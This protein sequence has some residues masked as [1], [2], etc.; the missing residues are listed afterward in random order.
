MTDI[1]IGAAEYGA[2]TEARMWVHE[3]EAAPLRPERYA[4]TETPVQVPVR[5]GISLAANLIA[6]TLPDGAQSPPCVVVTNGYSGLDFSLLPTLRELAAAGYPV[7]L[8]RL[9]GVAPSQG[10][11]GLY[12]M[13]GPDG[14]DV[15]EWAAAQPWNNGRVGMVGASLLGISQWLAAKQ[16]PEHLVVVVPDDSPNNTYDYLWYAGGLVPGPG[17]KGRAAVPGVESEYDVA[18]AHPWFDEYWA[19]H[20]ATREDIQQLA[21]EGLPALTSS[22]WD[23]YILDGS[24]RAFTWMR[25]AGAGSRAR[26]VLGPWPHAGMFSKT[27]VRGGLAPGETIE[28]FTGFELQLL[29][30]DR[31]LRDERNGIDEGPPVL[32]YVQGPDRWRHE[33]DWPLPDERR[34]RLF[35]CDDERTGTSASINDG[36]LSPLP[37]GRSASADYA[38]DPT[39]SRNPVD[40]SMMAMQMVADAE[41]IPLPVVLPDGS[42]RPYGRLIMDKAAYEADSLTWTSAILRAPTEVTGYP[43]IVLWAS[44][45]SSDAS[46]IAELMDVGP[47]ADGAWTSVQITRG[48]LRAGAQFSRTQDTVLPPG[49]VM[50]FEIELSPT[51]YV[52]PAGHRVRITV[53]GAAIDPA[54]DLAWHGPGLNKEPFAFSVHT[55][56]GF[57]SYADL[58]V[59]GF[60]DI[61]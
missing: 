55:G 12:E 32:I 37:P 50:R 17:R 48:A 60:G 4:V 29:W 26:L 43:R 46:F 5:D 44:V 13:Y 30:L 27:S 8:C 6:P 16:R 1:R 49:D 51:S 45:S 59:I 52:V 35:L 42:T 10:K 57:A 11:A 2:G 40:V 15:I 34:V 9:R 61:G 21:R 19:A 7:L 31:F 25:Q 33:H 36:A 3:R 54:L 41:P 38:F 56:A 20:S 53:Q 39:S 14:H 18:A 28:P 23:S 58:P 47:G 22:G 24:S